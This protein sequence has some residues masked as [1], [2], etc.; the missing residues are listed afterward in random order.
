MTIQYC[1]HREFVGGQ[2]IIEA[3]L[4]PGLS[5]CGI[6]DQLRINGRFQSLRITEGADRE[7]WRRQVEKP[8]ELTNGRDRGSHRA[9]AGVDPVGRPNGSDVP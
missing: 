2:D 7:R 4:N 9:N 5:A 1:E 6:V 3:A 8:D